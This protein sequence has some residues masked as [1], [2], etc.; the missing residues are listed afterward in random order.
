VRRRAP[1]SGVVRYEDTAT[2]SSRGSV[3]K[4][5]IVR[6]VARRDGVLQAC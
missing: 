6:D 3:S 4:D 1:R 5:A 2:S